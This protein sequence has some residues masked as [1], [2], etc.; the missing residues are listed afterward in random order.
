MYIC[1]V[2]PENQCERLFSLAF[3]KCFVK[4]TKSA[5]TII[6][7]YGPKKKN[8]NR[9]CGGNKLTYL[10]LKGFIVYLAYDTLEGIVALSLSCI[11]VPSCTSVK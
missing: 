5:P 3:I 1:T 11:S 9:T 10:K 2:E 6:F 8:I 7:F 4:L